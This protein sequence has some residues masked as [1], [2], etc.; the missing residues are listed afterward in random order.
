MS[1]FNIAKQHKLNSTPVECLN[2][3]GN[4]IFG[5]EKSI[6]KA[7]VTHNQFLKELGLNPLP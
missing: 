1:L 7:K 6:V 4:L 3:I 5:V 2:K